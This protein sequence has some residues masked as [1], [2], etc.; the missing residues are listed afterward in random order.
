MLHIQIITTH[1]IP[2]YLVW[3]SVMD[4][5][6]KWGRVWGGG[7]HSNKTNNTTAISANY[8]RR[9]NQSHVLV[10]GSNDYHSFDNDRPPPQH[11]VIQH[12]HQKPKSI[13]LQSEEQRTRYPVPS[14]KFQVSH[15][16]SQTVP[17]AQCG[18][19][20][21]EDSLLASA[22]K[23]SVSTNGSVSGLSHLATRCGQTTTYTHV[24][25]I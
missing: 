12:N 5:G 18:P 16:Q 19:N 10:H 25:V 8:S 22:P 4:G 3:T 11:Y 14:W 7:A 1:F 23:W 6:R 15:T 13:T 24:W 9:T 21:P 2:R 20:H 17:L